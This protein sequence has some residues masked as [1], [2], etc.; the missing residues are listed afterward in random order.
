MY[1]PGAV[2]AVAAVHVRSFKRN[3]SNDVR[4]K[5]VKNIWVSATSTVSK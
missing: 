4:F 5:K 2:Y 3:N 1:R